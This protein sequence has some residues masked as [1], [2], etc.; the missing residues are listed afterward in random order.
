MTIQTGDTVVWDF[1]GAVPSGQY[2]N[3]ASKSSTPAERGLERAHRNEI[4]VG[5]EMSWTFGKEGVYEYVCALHP[6]WSA[7]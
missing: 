4:Q 5:G 3:A 7:P 6:A 2:H 1:S